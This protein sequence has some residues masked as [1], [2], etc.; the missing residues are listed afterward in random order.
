MNIKMFTIIMPC[1][2]IVEPPT[3]QDV[4]NITAGAVGHIFPMTLVAFNLVLRGG[5]QKD[6]ALEIKGT[7]NEWWRPGGM[8]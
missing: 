6:G 8:D 4:M 5:L 3:A 1:H 2:C 7:D